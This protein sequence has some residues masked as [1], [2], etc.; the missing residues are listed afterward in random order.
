VQV[1]D[2]GRDSAPAGQRVA[3]NLTGIGVDQIARGDVL[4]APDGDLSPTFLIDAELEF[5]DRDHESEHGDRVQ[6]HHGTRETPARLAWLGGR[7]WQ[8]RLEQP[9][10]AEREDRLV[11]RQ[12]SPPSTLGGGRVLDAHPR[13]HGPGRDL[14]ARL[15][16]LARGEADDPGSGTPAG[17]DPAH[18]GPGA[19]PTPATPTSAPP[20]LSPSALALEERLRAAG[21]EP[22]IESEL[23]PAD[24]LALRTAGRA[25]RVS[26]TL[27]YH[28]DAL[29]H[30]RQRLLAVAQRHGDA[31]TLAQ[32]RD[33]LGTSRK[34]AQALLEHFDSERLTI[35]RGEAHQLRP[36]NR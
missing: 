6:V 14:L 3:V 17:P 9:L 7:F 5:A 35:R 18:G 28:P 32:L 2:Q 11:L 36:G 27:H 19:E 33:E 34:F 10:M 23:D 30:V 26:K 20:P 1:H 16:R 21:V 13:K 22:P 15:A 25:V 8:L 12:I 24:L 4:T 31:I 29:E